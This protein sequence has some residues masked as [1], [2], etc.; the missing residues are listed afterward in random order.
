MPAS[1]SGAIL[2]T[3]LSEYVVV[4][5]ALVSVA[6]TAD[7]VA[8]ALYPY[9]VESAYGKDTVAAVPP[10]TVARIPNCSEFGVDDA[11]VPPMALIVFVAFWSEVRVCPFMV[12]VYP[13][14]ALVDT[15]RE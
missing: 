2:A 11:A 1:V 12:I 10:E 13:D 5:A 9:E 8:V 7:V 14:G 4:L 15:P 3:Y 6:S